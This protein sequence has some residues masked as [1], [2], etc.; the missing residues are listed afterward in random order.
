MLKKIKKQLKKKQEES[1]MYSKEFGDLTAMV[2][3]GL[4]NDKAHAI[5]D[6]ITKLER[7]IV[8]DNKK[9][10][11]IIRDLIDETRKAYRPMRRQIDEVSDKLTEI[12]KQLR[13]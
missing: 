11:D 8:A 12:G 13:Y 2:W 7:K 10:R 9:K 6:K 3:E 4:P 1:I 5:T